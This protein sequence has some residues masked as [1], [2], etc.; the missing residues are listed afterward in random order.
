M[1]IEKLQ[2]TNVSSELNNY[3]Q[4]P[5]KGFVDFNW[6]VTLHP[7]NAHLVIPAIDHK[8]LRIYCGENLLSK[9]E[10]HFP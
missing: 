2:L 6:Q 8:I 7:V 5:I 3:F 4:Q 1:A 9:G 10:V